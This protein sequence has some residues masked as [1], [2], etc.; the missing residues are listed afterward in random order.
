MW[1][2]ENRSGEEGEIKVKRGKREGKE[3][4]VRGGEGKGDGI[5]GKEGVIVRV[6][7]G[8]REAVR[9]VEEGKGRQ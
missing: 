4:A 2:V 9:E 3:S 8:E 1:R 7:E 6:S 5:R